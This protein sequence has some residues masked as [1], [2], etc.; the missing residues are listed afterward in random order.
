MLA[1]LEQYVLVNSSDI[2]NGATDSST[3]TRLVNLYSL[4]RGL[5]RMSYHVPYSREAEELIFQVIN[6][7]AWS[8]L[9]ARIHSV[10]LKWLFQQENLLKSLCRQIL[11]FCRSYSSEG[12]DIMIYGA[13]NQTINVQTLAELV[14]S[15]DN[16]GARLLLCLLAQLVEEESHEHDIISVLDLITTIVGICPTASDQLCLHGLGTIIRTLCY[17]SR[18]FSMA[19]VMPVLVLVLNILGPVHSETISSDQCWVAVTMKVH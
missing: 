2:L 5:G 16:Y 18:T 15:V 13:H 10:S 7:D 4:F 9:S 14:S 17:S 8:L 6:E 11:K 12:T 1:S 19:I 3:V